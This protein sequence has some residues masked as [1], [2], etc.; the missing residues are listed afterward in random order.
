MYMT[1]DEVAALLRI[2][3]W[4]VGRMVKNGELTAVKADGRNGAIRVDADSVTDYLVRHT[5]NAT[6]STRSR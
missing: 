3:R 6:T 2:S 1:V 5:V 4:T